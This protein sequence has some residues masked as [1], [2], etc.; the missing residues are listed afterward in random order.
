MHRHEGYTAQILFQRGGL[1]YPGTQKQSTGKRHLLYES[2]PMP[3]LIDQTGG[4]ASD[5]AKDEAKPILDVIP[6]RLHI[7]IPLIIGSQE[8]VELVQSFLQE[9]QA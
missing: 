5:G 1:I 4:P 7:R 6:D 8:N 3:N 2:A 9:P